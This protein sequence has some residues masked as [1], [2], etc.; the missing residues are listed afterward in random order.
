MRCRGG[1]SKKPHV[2]TL[3]RLR[4]LVWKWIPILPKAGGQ[5]ELVRSGQS[6][7]MRSMPFTYKQATLDFKKKWNSERNLPCLLCQRTPGSTPTTI[8]MLVVGTCTVISQLPLAA[9]APNPTATR[10]NK[11]W[12]GR[13]PPTPRPFGIIRSRKKHCSNRVV[14]RKLK[15]HLTP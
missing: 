12:S 6:K 10:L 1:A 11:P 14:N 3:D 5:E 9:K 13:N 7:E 8:P 4:R 2:V 15:P